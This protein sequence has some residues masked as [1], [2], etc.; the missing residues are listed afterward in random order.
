MMKQ[1]KLM[2]KIFFYLTIISFILYI[3][4]L[5][6]HYEDLKSILLGLFTSIVIVFTSSYASYRIELI[7]NLKEIIHQL[8]YLIL[9]MEKFNNNFDVENMNIEN[10]IREYKKIYNKMKKLDLSDNNISSFNPIIIK[11]INRI[12]KT[13]MS[14]NGD[15]DDLYYHLLLNKRIRSINTKKK[16]IKS[17]NDC[18]YMFRI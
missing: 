6:K 12:K 10:Y 8:I 5:L 13:F 4:F 17:A 7:Y 16:L 11:R 1:S 14:F 9:D 15:F 18:I 3:V 2:V